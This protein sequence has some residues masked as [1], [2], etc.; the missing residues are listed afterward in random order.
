MDYPTW[1]VTFT[2]YEDAA[3]SRTT[4]DLQNLTQAVQCL[5][6]QQAQAMIEAQFMGRA[7]VWS[8]HQKG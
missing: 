6:P 8:V 4:T 7:H 1:E 2:I 5:H 3:H